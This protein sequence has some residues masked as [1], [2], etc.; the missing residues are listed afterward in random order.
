MSIEVV[1][2]L[3]FGTVYRNPLDGEKTVVTTPF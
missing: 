1:A 3:K 2:Y